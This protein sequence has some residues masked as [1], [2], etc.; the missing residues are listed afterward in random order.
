MAGALALQRSEPA[1]AVRA[2]VTNEAP[3]ETPVFLHQPRLPKYPAVAS[4]S[5]QRR[6]LID[7]LRAMGVP[8]DVLARVVLADLDKGWNQRGAELAVKFH[9]DPDKMAALQL[10][11]DRNKDTE[12][13][14]ALGEEG[15]RQWDQGNML[16][17]V[18]Q[19]KIQL[20]AAET[21]QAYD[22]WKKVQQRQL[23]LEQAKAEGTMDPADI[24]DAS[25]KSASDFSQQMK[26]LLGDE[27]YAESQQADDVST[28]LTQDLASV[29]PSGSQFQELLKAQQQWND[30]HAALDQQFQT[31]QASADYAAQIQTLNDSRDQAY[32]QVLGTNAFTA[33]QKEQDPG[34]NQMKKYETLWGLDDNKI[35]SVY[36]AMKYYQKSVE[37]YQAQVSALQANGQNVDWDTANKNVQ[38]F[39]DQTQQSLQNYLG[40]DVFDKM[41][42]NGVF[43]LSLPALAGHNT[44]SQH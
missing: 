40:Q 19:G 39:A 24:N 3:V 21:D 8:N 17:E 41:L 13:R 34:Y 10:E 28:A 18:N 15:F 29:N 37:D 36:G 14:A 44:Q 32:R 12:M 31:N 5:D 25:D 26:A 38:K 35:D 42:G 6:W 11:I 23:D 4:A 16:R 2:G 33:L 9:G 7:Q 1:P 27:R 30:Q 20:T 43:Q 22:L